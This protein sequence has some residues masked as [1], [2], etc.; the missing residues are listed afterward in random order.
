MDLAVLR[1]D[2]VDSLE[3]EAKDVVSSE[4]VGLALRSVPRHEFL[5]E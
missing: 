5:P 2:M 1:D 3:H 4:A